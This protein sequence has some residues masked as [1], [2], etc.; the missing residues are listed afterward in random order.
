MGSELLVWIGAAVATAFV[1]AATL[2]GTALFDTV[3]AVRD[4][5][6]ANAGSQHTVEPPWWRE[7]IIGHLAVLA[8]DGVIDLQALSASKRPKAN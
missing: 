5:A 3:T 2:I 4:E 6:G 7:E 1:G 8:D